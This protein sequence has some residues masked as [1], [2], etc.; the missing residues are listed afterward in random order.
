MLN[1]SALV[2]YQSFFFDVNNRFKNRS[3]NVHVVSNI[4]IFVC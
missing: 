3:P 4:T 2:K 1:N